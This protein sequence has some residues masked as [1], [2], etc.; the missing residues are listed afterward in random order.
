VHDPPS[1]LWDLDFHFDQTANGRTI[2]LLNVIDEFTR[3]CPAIVEVRRHRRRWRSRLPR[4][5]HAEWGAPVFLWFDNGPGALFIDPGSPCQNAWVECFNGRLR[6]EFLNG[7]RF[8]FLLEAEVLIEDWRID[9][10]LNRPCAR[11]RMAGSAPSSSP[12]DGP[13]DT[14]PKG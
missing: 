5:N 12:E 9:Y 11:V 14:S 2:R 10:N 8:D 1:V 3:E 4:S 7:H 13:T 6:D